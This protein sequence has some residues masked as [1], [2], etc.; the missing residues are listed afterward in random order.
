MYAFTAYVQ[1]SVEFQAD[2]APELLVAM[3]ALK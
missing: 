2:F 3:A 1:L